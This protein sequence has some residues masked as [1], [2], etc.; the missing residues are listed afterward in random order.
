M[1]R[2]GS[3]DVANNHPLSLWETTAWMQELGRRRKPR[4]GVRERVL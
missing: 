4:A 2:D 3:P 1:N